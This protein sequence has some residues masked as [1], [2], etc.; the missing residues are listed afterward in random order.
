MTGRAFLRQAK[1][2]TLILVGTALA[3]GCGGSP[4][5]NLVKGRILY[6]DEPLKNQNFNQAVVQFHEATDS[7]SPQI[8]YGTF[9]EEG[10]YSIKVPP[11]KYRVAVLATGAPKGKK[12]EDEYAP[13]VSII[14]AN[15]ADPKLSKIEIEVS[16][17]APPENYTINLKK[18]GS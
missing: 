14:P 9:D 8:Y 12:P 3:C 1:T 4:Q 5:E 18:T 6:G 13:P 15:Y 11:G 17:S 2:L 16:D 10:N 7:K